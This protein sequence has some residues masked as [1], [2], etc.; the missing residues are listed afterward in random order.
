VSGVRRKRSNHPATITPAHNGVAV[1]CVQNGDVHGSPRSGPDV[2]SL[3]V[4]AAPLDPAADFL[5]AALDRVEFDRRQRAHV[6]QRHAL[7]RLEDH[8]AGP[9]GPRWCWRP[10]LERW[11]PPLQP[12]MSGHVLDCDCG[13]CSA[14][15]WLCDELR[16]GLPLDPY[17]HED[18]ARLFAAWGLSPERTARDGSTVPFPLWSHRHEPLARLEDLSDEQRAARAAW[19]PRP[20]HYRRAWE[21]QRRAPRF[22]LMGPASTQPVQGTIDLTRRVSP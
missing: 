15:E 17:R 3:G 13:D 16:R 22:N 2:V 19:T 7:E 11:A 12:L 20:D 5:E 14:I 9:P 1:E 8:A 4:T 18:L 6:E 10:R 21:I